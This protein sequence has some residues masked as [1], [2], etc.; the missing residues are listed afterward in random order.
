MR[1]F[2]FITSDWSKCLISFP[3]FPIF[4]WTRF[5][6]YFKHFLFSSHRDLNLFLF[7][8]SLFST[9]IWLLNQ[10]TINTAEVHNR[11]GECSGNRNYSKSLLFVSFDKVQKSQPVPMLEKITIRKCIWVPFIFDF[12]KLQNNLQLIE[13]KEQKKHCRSWSNFHRDKFALID[14]KI[15]INAGELQGGNY[16]NNKTLR[17]KVSNVIFHCCEWNQK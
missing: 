16:N 15:E 11:D 5:F 1:T 9:F 2:I 4:F 7:V 12:V 14:S 8:L 3:T 10:P 13:K 6:K 17:E